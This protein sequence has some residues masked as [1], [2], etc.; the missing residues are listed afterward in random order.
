MLV[1]S[2][3]IAVGLVYWEITANLPPLDKIAQYHPPVATQVLADDGT[4]IGEF[5]FEK[6]YL[7]PI[8]RIPAVVRH[9]FI[10]A[11]DDGFYRHGGVDPFSILRALINNVAAGGKVQGGST[12]TQQVIKSLL[13][14][15]KK[16]YERKLKE[17]VLAMRLER[18]F[19][20][21]EIPGVRGS[22]R[23]ARSGAESPMTSLS[24]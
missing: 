1:L 13:L 19:T 11:E 24:S 3:A 20:K 17:M 6:R 7:V 21:D 15:P 23:R 16:S 10:A 5:Y 8:D 12:I 14:T 4:V 18:Q 2:G 22:K 9:A